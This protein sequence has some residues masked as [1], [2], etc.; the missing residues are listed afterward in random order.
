MIRRE[1]ESERERETD[2]QT[3]RQT[4]REG[5]GERVDASRCDPLKCQYTNFVKDLIRGEM[6]QP[7][8]HL[9]QQ[10]IENN[11]TISSG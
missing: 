10:K 6:D 7:M 8:T 1:R 11:A 5:E 9:R 3:D 4:E 2:R